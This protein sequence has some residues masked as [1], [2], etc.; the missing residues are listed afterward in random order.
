MQNRESTRNHLATDFHFAS[1][2]AGQALARLTPSM[3]SILKQ[4]DQ[5]FFGRHADDPCHEVARA[6]SAGHVW[7]GDENRKQAP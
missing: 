1:L 7:H 3:S 5:H 4:K 2:T 6:C